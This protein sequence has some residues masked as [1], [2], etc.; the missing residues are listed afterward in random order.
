MFVPSYV[1]TRL[2]YSYYFRYSPTTLVLI[3]DIKIGIR[4]TKQDDKI[5]INLHFVLVST[6]H[7]RYLKPIPINL[8]VQINTLQ[9]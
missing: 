1:W 6:N 2:L 7:L 9:G 4:Q 3:D 5:R 8:N